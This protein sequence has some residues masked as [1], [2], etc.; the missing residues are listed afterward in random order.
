MKKDKKIIIIDYYLGNTKSVLHALNH[1][2]FSVKISAD[3]DEIRESIGVILPGVGAFQ[4]GIE[5]LRKKKLDLLLKE[6]IKEGKPFLGICLGMQ[7][8]FE[9]G[10][11]HGLYQGLGIIPGR[12]TRFPQTLRVPHLGWNQVKYCT[13]EGENTTNTTDDLIFRGISDNSYFYFVHSYYCVPEIGTIVKAKT[14]YHQKFTSVI[15]KENIFGVQFHPEKS[16]K[17]GLKLL[18]NFGEICFDYNSSN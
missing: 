2:G 3:L 12:V 18:K 16:S 10:E 15:A 13:L 14:E 1:L 9:Y 4:D 7:L 11:E 8:L 6:I 17:Q 5:V